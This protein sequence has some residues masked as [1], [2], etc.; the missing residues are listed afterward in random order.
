MD[1]GSLFPYLLICYMVLKEIEFKE[2]PTHVKVSK[3]KSFKISTQSIYNQRLHHHERSK[4][5]SFMKEYIKNNLPLNWRVTEGSY[6]I[7]M[8]L[9]FFTPINWATVRMSKGEVKWSKPTKDYQAKHD[10]DNMSWIWGKTIQDCLKDYGI[11]P[12][13]TVDFI[14]DV[15]YAYREIDSFDERRINLKLVKE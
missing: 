6:P 2:F 10:L 1:K 5:I 11:I 13:D 15:E 9:T 14:N 12:E 7:K 8:L 3:T 4:I